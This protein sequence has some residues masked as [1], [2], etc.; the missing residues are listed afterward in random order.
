MYLSKNY[1]A[2]KETNISFASLSPAWGGGQKASNRITLSE[3]PVW[4][5][6]CGQPG[7]TNIDMAN[8]IKKKKVGEVVHEHI[9]A[10]W[11][12]AAA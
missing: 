12:E 8:H 5:D 9:T 3:Q 11:L 4:S 10:S 6:H 7:V 1:A 2:L